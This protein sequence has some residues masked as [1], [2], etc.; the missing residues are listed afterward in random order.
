[1]SSPPPERFADQFDDLLLAAVGGSEVAHA[2]LFRALAPAV[3]GYLRA[4]GSE[5][6]DG[7][8]NEVFLRAFRVLHTFRGDASRFRSWIFT[9]ARNCLI[10]ERR[11][12]ARRPQVVVLPHTESPDLAPDAETEALA[13][14]A[15]ERVAELLAGVSEDQRDVLLLRIVADLSVEQTAEVLGKSREAVKA[16]TRRGLAALERELQRQGVSR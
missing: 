6:P 15:H 13:R 1:M 11:R 14:L 4:R 8:A 9:I 5:D 2:E 3:A 7:L 10:D 12:A 16:L